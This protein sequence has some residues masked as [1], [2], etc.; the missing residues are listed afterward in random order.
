MFFK[1]LDEDKLPMAWIT[2]PGSDMATYSMYL[3]DVRELQRRT[4]AQSESIDLILPGAAHIPF[5]SQPKDDRLLASRK[6]KWIMGSFYG[7]K[8]PKVGPTFERL[9]VKGA[10]AVV[11]FKAGTAKGLSAQA[12][13]LDLFELA[14]ED[15][16]FYPS[17]AK[18]SGETIV[19][20]SE[21]VTQPVYVQF[22]RNGHPEQGLTNSAGLP[23]IGF[24]TSSKWKCNFL[25]AKWP[26]KEGNSEPPHDGVATIAIKVADKDGLTETHMN[27][28]TYL[29]KDGNFH[30]WFEHDKPFS[31]DELTKWRTT[32][33]EHEM[34]AAEGW[35]K[36]EFDDSSWDEVTLPSRWIPSHV[37]IFR[38]SFEMDDPAAYEGYL[39]RIFSYKMKTFKAYL[40]GE[41]IVDITEFP[42]KSVVSNI[43]LKDYVKSLLKKGTN[44]LAVIIDNAGLSASHGFRIAGFNKSLKDLRKELGV[45]LG[46]KGKKGKKKK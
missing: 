32:T 4:A 27:T 29:V 8:G 16:L 24:T 13:A 34:N 12:K 35:F 21:K 22:S 46:E 17:K 19:L 9:E 28:G 43:D 38:A 26:Q 1:S 11:H 30:H 6:H 44:H 20:S 36:P 45:G 3:Q 33:I 2:P 37:A 7:A 10:S 18:I 15:G 31:E 14:G 25:P 40:N 41:V 42:K 39:M 5:S 23:A